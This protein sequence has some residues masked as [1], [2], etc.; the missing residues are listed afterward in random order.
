[1]G[2]AERERSHLGEADQPPDSDSSGTMDEPR[3][4]VSWK[5]NYPPGQ[6]LHKLHVDLNSAR[7]GAQRRR[8]DLQ[9][10]MRVRH[11]LAHCERLVVGQV[12]HDHG[13]EARAI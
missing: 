11:Q 12:A 1:M 6:K 5:C 7:L 9:G 2:E 3:P 8:H 13:D 10:H 4:T